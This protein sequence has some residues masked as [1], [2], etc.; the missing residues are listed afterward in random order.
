MWFMRH[1]F[2]NV[3]AVTCMLNPFPL[4]LI[5]V[6]GEGRDWPRRKVSR[7]S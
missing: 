6:Q 5:H 1:A 2:S 3:A 7:A 4:G